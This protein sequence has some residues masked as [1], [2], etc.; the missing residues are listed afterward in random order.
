MWP[1]RTVNCGRLPYHRRLLSV[2][3]ALVLVGVAVTGCSKGSPTPAAVSRTLAA[4][5][6]AASTG[7]TASVDPTAR[8]LVVRLQ[9]SAYSSDTTAALITA[10]ARSGVQ[11]FA[12]PGAATPEQPVNG[13]ASTM[14]LL[15]FQAHALAVGAWAGA[16]YSGA[17]LDT[18]LPRPPDNTGMPSTSE[19]LAGYVAA[20]QTPGATFSRALMAGQ[21]LLVPAG[22]RFPAVVLVLF[23]ADLASMGPSRSTATGSSQSRTSTYRDAGGMHVQTVAA[24]TDGP[25]TTG[26]NWINNTIASFFNALHVA[27]P[28]NL[29]GAIFG[30]IWNWLVDAGQAF[31]QH[32]ISTVTDAVLSTI[33][34]IAAG[35][36]AV[37]M[38]I[39]SILPYAVKVMASGDTGGTTFTLG[40]TPLS[41]TFTATVTAGDLPGWPPVLADCAAVASVKLPDFSRKDIPLTWGPLEAPADPL[42]QP[43]PSASDTATTDASGRATW[44]FNTAT[45]PGDPKGEQRSQ[46]DAMPVAV[47][48]PEITRARTALTEALVGY[49]PGLLRPVVGRLFAPYVDGLQDRLNNILDARG[50]GTAILV[51]HDGKPPTPSPTPPPATATCTPQPV[52]PGTYTGVNTEEFTEKLPMTGNVLEVH[53]TA[54]GPVTMSVIASGSVTGHWSFHMHQVQDER[55]NLAGVSKDL[56]S[57]LTWAM[58]AGTISGTVCQLRVTSG[59]VRQL[60]CVGVCGNRDLAASGSGASRVLGRPTSAAPGRLTWRLTLPSTSYTDLFAFTVAGPR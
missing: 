26:A 52:L 16:A 43:A 50:R 20:V 58:D 14:R 32:L 37:A 23:A 44:A 8:A 15:A 25:C 47:H 60:S 28:D 12:D 9:Q 57:V 51:F 53:I 3:L 2:M 17:E 11:T 55:V 1:N 56:H 18:V 34:S 36:S 30:A 35:V 39:A 7:A 19:L 54:S 33:R 59:S 4:V 41:G 21:N 48:R 31:V 13:P 38:Q 22:L 6:P 5:T 27:T 10:L 45:D 42:L 29:P 40:S 46:V 49:I 24:S